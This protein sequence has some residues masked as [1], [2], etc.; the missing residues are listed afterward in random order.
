MMDFWNTKADA[1]KVAMTV[2]MSERLD[3]M[4]ATGFFGGGGCRRG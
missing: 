1:L 2:D 4:E 3:G